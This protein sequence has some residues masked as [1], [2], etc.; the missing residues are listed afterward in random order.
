MTLN[1][2]YNKMDIN[3]EDKYRLKWSSTDF[4]W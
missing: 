2:I 4:K 3:G 1:V